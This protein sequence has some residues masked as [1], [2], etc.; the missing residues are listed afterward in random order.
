M[1]FSNVD[2][3]RRV[4]YEYH[5]L[6]SPQKISAIYYNNHKIIVKHHYLMR[7]LLDEKYNQPWHFVLDSPAYKG[8]AD[9]ELKL[10]VYNFKKL[11]NP[12]ILSKMLLYSNKV[13]RLE[14]QYNDLIPSEVIEKLSNLKVNEINEARIQESSIKREIK[15][16]HTA[17]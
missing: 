9:G 11:L 15:E 13:R 1:N 16:D 14:G 6:H 7:A 4:E 2:N 10:L 3:S 12:K 17:Q 8:M 5:W